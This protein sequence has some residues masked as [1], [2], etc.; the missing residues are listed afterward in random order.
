MDNENLEKQLLQLRSDKMQ[1]DE[2]MST[3][4]HVRNKSFK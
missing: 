2:E 1:I 4:N 3:V